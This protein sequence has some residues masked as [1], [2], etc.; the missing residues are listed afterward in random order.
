[1]LVTTIP[2]SRILPLV[3]SQPLP[4]ISLYPSL[5]LLGR[6]VLKRGEVVGYNCSDVGASVV[7]ALVLTKVKS[8]EYGHVPSHTLPLSYPTLSSILGD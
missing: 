5:G 7:E 4:S 8:L 1:M 6:V 3:V 2:G